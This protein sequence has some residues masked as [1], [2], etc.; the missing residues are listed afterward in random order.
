MLYMTTYSN[1]NLI[2]DMIMQLSVIVGDTICDIEVTLH[3]GVLTSAV[4]CI[5][6]RV[7]LFTATAV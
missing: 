6:E 4:Y 3:R 1:N 7:L 2:L 5:C